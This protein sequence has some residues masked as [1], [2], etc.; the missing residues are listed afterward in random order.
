MEE[1]TKTVLS[2][3]WEELMVFE[4]DIATAR[5]TCMQHNGGR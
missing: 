5:G 2:M 3:I 4:S 1:I